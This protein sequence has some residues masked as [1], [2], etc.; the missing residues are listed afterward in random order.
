MEKIGEK[1]M[2][3]HLFALM[4]AMIMAMLTLSVSGYIL[5]FLTFD[6]K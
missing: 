6:V 2:E 1:I 3:P 5:Y 4:I